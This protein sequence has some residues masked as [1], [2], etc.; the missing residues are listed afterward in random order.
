MILKYT[1]SGATCREL[2]I[3]GTLNLTGNCYSLLPWYFNWGENTGWTQKHSL[4]SSSYKIKTYWNIFINMGLQ[5]H[6]LKKFLI[7]PPATRGQWNARWRSLH[8]NAAGA[9][10]TKWPGVLQ[11]APEITGPDRLWLFPLGGTWRT[12]SMYLHYPQPWM[13]CGN[14]SLQL[15]TRS[16]RIC[17]RE[18]GP[19]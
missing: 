11:V 15:S 19:S 18:S 16:R 5:I 7:F 9:C 12:E 6:Q 17:C 10:W 14:A 13:S 2:F 4:I 1:A 8:S 3:V